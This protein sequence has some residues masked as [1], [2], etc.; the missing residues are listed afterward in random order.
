MTVMFDSFF[1]VHPHLVRSGIW[2]RMKAGEKDLYIFLCHQSE[3]FQTR[4][5]SATDAQ[6]RDGVGAASRTLCDARKR[7]Q[8]KGLVRYRAGHGNKYQYTM[9]NPRTLE[10][11][12]GDP[13]DRVDKPKNR[14]RPKTA[15]EP[16]S[17]SARQILPVR[18][19][20]PTGLFDG[21]TI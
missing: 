14:D 19:E 3:K 13:R 17:E 6:V 20:I 15:A 9:C 18:T 8:E 2:A 7:L 4:E 16:T 5:F 1:G 21:K 11:Y 10:P 12:P